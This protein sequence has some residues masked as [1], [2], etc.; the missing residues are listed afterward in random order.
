M[1]PVAGRL[2]PVARP[3]HSRPML[4][5]VSPPPSSSEASA[6]GRIGV[7]PGAPYF[8]RA[9]GTAWT[10]VGH[11]ESIAWPNLAP[12][13]ARRDPAAV[14]AHLHHLK[15]SGVTCLRLMLECAHSRHRY[16]E[17]PFGR[18]NPT[19]VTLWDDL[20]AACA[21]AGL[22]ILLTPF[23]TFWTWKRWD[24]HPYN[25]R[26]GG[27]LDSPRRLLLDP[28]VRAAAKARLGFAAER[29]GGSGALFAWDLWN[30][31]HPAHAE[32]S[33][34]IFDD[35][36]HDLSTHVREVEQRCFGHS[37][38]QTVSLFGPELDG[39]PGLGRPIFEH[40]DLDFATIHIY[41]QGTIDLPR[42]TVDPAR[43]MGRIVRDCVL[44]TAPERPFLDSEHGPIHAFKDKR[45]TLPEAFDEEM[46]RHMQWAHL[47][48]GGAGGGMRW[49]NRH[50]HVLTPGMNAEQAKLAA[51]L[52]L[53]DWPGFR[54]RN[55]SAEIVTAPGPTHLAA[56]GCGDDRQAVVFLL[57][58]DTVGSDGRLAAD[59]RP[60]APLVR[61]PGLAPGRYALTPFDPQTGLAGRAASVTHGDEGA[62]SFSAP[63]FAA[64]LVLALRRVG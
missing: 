53:I 16:F 15:A 10:P 50:P 40:P 45:R 54:R 43:D 9:D 37:H 32:D 64:S 24:H 25:A 39:E 61:L 19:M 38:L 47:A 7:A 30:E 51:F 27:P 46:F 4:S 62:L 31:I 56:F 42:N 63:P 18:L 55:I 44:R 41:A 48:S 14:D 52:P 60:V 23:D 33:F 36:I 20:F 57:R 59:A 34:D 1:G 6:S 21:R 12:L 29:W 8:T 5:P 49:P 3:P 2:D 28:Q 22:H 26:H 17:R 35:F 11:N 58:R 13:F